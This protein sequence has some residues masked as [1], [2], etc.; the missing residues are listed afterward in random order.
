MRV[1]KQSEAV[2][3]MLDNQPNAVMVVSCGLSPF[4]QIAEK[5]KDL[6][7]QPFK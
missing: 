6:Y 4:L 7:S 3:K 5:G 1:A 2:N